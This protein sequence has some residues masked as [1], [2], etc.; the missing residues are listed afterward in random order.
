M[1][2]SPNISDTCKNLIQWQAYYDADMMGIVVESLI[3]KYDE[4]AFDIIMDAMLEK[5][6]SDAEELKECGI[7]F[8][9]FAEFGRYFSSSL[10]GI[11]NSILSPKLPMEVEMDRVILTHTACARDEA[12]KARG[13]SPE[14]RQRL[15]DLYFGSFEAYLRGFFPDIKIIKEKLLPKG[16]EVCRIVF[17][18]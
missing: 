3:E 6:R 8:N 9:S 14:M 2:E 11:V 15:C 5:G 17:E 10:N 12:W 7:K 13:Y 18:R 16:D 1:K 4:E